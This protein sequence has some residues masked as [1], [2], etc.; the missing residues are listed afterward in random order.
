MVI[1]YLIIRRAVGILGIALPFILLL[2]TW[3]IG[4]CHHIKGSVSAYYYTIMGNCLTGVLCGVALFLFAYKG[5][6]LKSRISPNL[7]SNIACIFA[8]G[9]AFFP[10]NCDHIC[11]YC[12]ILCR[13]DSPVSNTVHYFS[14]AIFF[15]TLT[16]ISIFQFTELDPGKTFTSQKRKRNKIYRTC[17]YIMAVSVIFIPALKITAVHEALIHYKP[18]FLLESI[19][20]C[21]FGVSW[22]VKGETIFKDK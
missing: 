6:K 3:I 19:A 15:I 1:S 16:Y 9:T 21:S 18:E 7:T 2:G 4:N 14:A 10:T 12:N 5:P 22:L 17:G 20:L 8:L 11:N 13:D